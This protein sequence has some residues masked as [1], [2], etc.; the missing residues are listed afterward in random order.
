MYTF[1]FPISAL[2]NFE[3]CVCSMV[4]KTATIELPPYSHAH[5]LSMV[6]NQGKGSRPVSPPMIQVKTTFYNS[7]NFK[8][9]FWARV[10]IVRLGTATIAVTGRDRA[11]EYILVIEGSVP[12]FLVRRKHSP[13]LYPLC[14]QYLTI[15]VRLYNCR[16]SRQREVG[17]VLSTD[18]E[19]RDWPFYH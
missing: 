12:P 19:G 1:L 6:V 9:P 13:N 3:L 4:C 5:V 14:L 7:Y 11:K 8:I 15:P 2:S 18:N 10:Q 17:W 16:Q